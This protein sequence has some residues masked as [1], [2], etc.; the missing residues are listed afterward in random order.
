MITF[1][2][3]FGIGLVVMALVFVFL[4]KKE[5]VIKAQAIPTSVTPK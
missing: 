2:I 5:I 1:L 3:G 4:L